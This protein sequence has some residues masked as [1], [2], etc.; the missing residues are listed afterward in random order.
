MKRALL[1]AAFGGIAFSLF[2]TRSYSQLPPVK[3]RLGFRSGYIHTLDQLSDSFGGGGHLTL[4]FTERVINRLYFDLRIAAIYLGDTKKPEIAEALTNTEG[5]LSEMRILY[6]SVG[7]Q[8]TFDLAEYWTAYASA[9]VGVY[10]VSILFDSGIQ[11]FD[12]S[13][14][15][16]GANFGGGV[17]WR[18]TD[19]LNLDLNFTAHHFWTEETV[20]DLYYFFTDQGDSSPYLLQFATGISYDLR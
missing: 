2:P 1:I 6:F 19:V 15:H 20:A 18:F 5:I 12:T 13:D 14:Q 8:Y 16:V 17:L 3:E 4:H 11:A 7:P 9:G 10:S